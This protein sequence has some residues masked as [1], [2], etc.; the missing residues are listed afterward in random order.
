MTEPSTLPPDT[1]GRAS[2]LAPG[3]AVAMAMA[4]GLAVANIYYNQPMLGLIERGFHGRMIA[5]LIPTATQLGYAAGLFLLVPLGDIM[6]RRRLIVGQFLALGLA[7]AAAALAPTAGILLVA[8]LALGAS[9]SVAQQ[10]VPFAAGLATPERRGG[11][12]G[13][14][15]S[16]LFCGILLSRALAGLVATAAGWRAMF[17]LAVP[18]VLAASLLMAVTLPRRHPH[19][20]LRY[21]AAL[22]SLGRLWTDEPS[23]R[24]ATLV[25]ALLFASFS[26]FWTILALLLQ[27][28]RYHLGADAAGLFGV[29]GIGG[30]IAAPF[31]GRLADR[32]GPIAT[33]IGGAAVA[34][35][36]WAMFG[37]WGSLA[38]IG[39]GVVLLDLGVQVALVSNQ[40]R[41]YALDPQARSR[42]TT[43]FMTGTFLGGACGSAGATLAWTR[44]GWTGVC[45]FGAGLALLA[46]AIMAPAAWTGRT[47]VPAPRSLH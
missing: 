35:L 6:D 37:L 21:G 29:V 19:A 43:L 24:Q 44:F 27:Q 16:G 15:M 33:V 30:I 46:V 4:A 11:A 7:L 5:G 36:S 18:L 41:I 38:G 45:C 47:R 42:L 34:L 12:V 20:G 9:A 39:V 26:T 1:P 17:W 23:L 10:I 3:L 14:V 32:N 22:R 40:H 2:G 28:P 25:Q 8:S 13:T 31:A